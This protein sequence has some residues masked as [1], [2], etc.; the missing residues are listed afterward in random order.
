MKLGTK[1][2]HG[3]LP[4][5]YDVLVTAGTNGFVHLDIKLLGSLVDNLFRRQVVGG[6]W[7][8]VTKPPTDFT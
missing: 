6:G 1:Q 3:D 5:N 8:V 2:I 4:G 7:S